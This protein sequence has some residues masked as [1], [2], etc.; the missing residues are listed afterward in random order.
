VFG[1]NKDPKWDKVIDDLLKMARLT[2]YSNAYPSSLSG[3]M[4][5]RV[6]TLRA[7][8]YQPEILLMDEPFGALDEILRERLDMELLQLWSKFGQTIIFITHNV[9]EAVLVSDR[10]Y[11]MVMKPE[12]VIADEPIS[13]LDVSIRAQV[14]N[15]MSALQKKIP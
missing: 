14:L 6:G 13:A 3:G 8:A 10:I 12:L 9:N 1:D 5:Q 7:M 2:E 11:V 4:L 15:L